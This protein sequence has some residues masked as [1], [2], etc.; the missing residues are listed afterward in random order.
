MLV[1]APQLLKQ[2]RMGSDVNVEIPLPYTQQS[3]QAQ[4][5]DHKPLRKDIY[6]S[7]TAS[8]KSK[9]PRFHGQS[10]GEIL[11]RDAKEFKQECVDLA[12]DAYD[13]STSGE[14]NSE[15]GASNLHFLWCTT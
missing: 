8:T 6:W 1:V 10:S 7:A 15:R 4:R 13:E 5:E 9:E 14:V 11:L 3:P 2:V 12:V